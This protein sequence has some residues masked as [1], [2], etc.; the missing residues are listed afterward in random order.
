MFSKNKNNRRDDEG[1]DREERLRI[2][3]QPTI[4]EL[5]RKTIE[6]EAER[7]KKRLAREE[8]QFNKSQAVKRQK[9]ER[10][11]APL[12]LIMT[13]LAAFFLYWRANLP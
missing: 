4:A 6:I 10:W 7:E 3:H 5:E 2:A 8:K 12:L 1:D 13:L 9:M 11:I